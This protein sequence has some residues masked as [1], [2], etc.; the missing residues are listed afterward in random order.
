M[1]AQYDW[2]AQ[3]AHQWDTT[4]RAEGSPPSSASRICNT[5]LYAMF[6]M[7]LLVLMAATAASIFGEAIPSATLSTDVVTVRPIDPHV[8]SRSENERI[9]R[10]VALFTNYLGGV[11]KITVITNHY[12]E[13]GTG[14]C[15]QEADGTWK[16][17]KA[18]FVVTPDGGAEARRGL[19]KVRLKP[20]IYTIGAVQLTLPNGHSMSSAPRGLYLHDPSADKR[21]L[22]SSITNSIGT[23][24]APNTVVYSNCFDGFQAD[25]VLKVTPAGF[26]QD[27]VLR[28]SLSWVPLQELGL[29]PASTVLEVWT[30]FF[31]TPVP[32]KQ[33]T[34]ITARPTPE[35]TA[36]ALSDETLKF[37][38]MKMPRGRAFSQGLSNAIERQSAQDS[39]PVGK[40]WR[41]MEDGRRFLIEAARWREILPHFRSLDQGLSGQT[42]AALLPKLR[43]TILSSTSS[44]PALL[45][46]SSVQHAAIQ[47]AENTLTQPPA[48]ILDY[49]IV[50]GALPSYV[51]APAETYFISG[52]VTIAGETVLGPGAVLKFADWSTSA[53]L[54]FGGTVRC[55]SRAG[56]SCILTAKDDNSVGEVIAGS[57]GLPIEFYGSPALGFNDDA[58]PA[59]LKYVRI[60]YAE[61]AIDF[62]N[63][64]PNRVRHCQI[65][66]AGW[67]F[68]LHG[69][70]LTLHNVLSDNSGS[71]FWGYSFSVY[72][73]HVTAHGG[74]MM[75]LW[76]NDP[77]TA[78]FINSL[79]VG[80]P[81]C[82][83]GMTCSAPIPSVWLTSEPQPPV[84]ETSLYGA[85]YLPADSDY[86]GQGTA[87]IDAQL[88]EELKHK[89][90]R[91]P[92]VTL[93]G[94][95][96]A[97]LT[98]VPTVARNVGPN[99]DLGYSY[100]AVD[101]LV[102][103]LWLRGSATLLATNGVVVGLNASAGSGIRLDGA[104]K[105][106]SEGTPLNL[107]RF[108]E[109]RSVQERSGPSVPYF[110][111]F[112]REYSAPD[113]IEL[114]L[115]FTDLPGRAGLNWHLDTDGGAGIVS[116]SDCQVIGGGIRSAFTEG[117]N[118]SFALTNNLL[119]T[120]KIDILGSSA[121]QLEFRN[122]TFIRG[123]VSLSGGGSAW[124]VYDNIFDQVSL[125][126]SPSVG[127]SHNAY[128]L[129][130]PLPSLGPNYVLQ[131]PV[132][133]QQG[134][135]GRFYLPAGSSPLLSGGSRGPAQAALFHHTTRVTQ[136]KEGSK[137]P[138][139]AVDLG[140]HYVALQNGSPWDTDKDGVADIYEDRNN[141][142]AWD[143]ELT[144]WQDS[145][146]DQDGFADGGG[147]LLKWFLPV[148]F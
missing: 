96:S 144:D 19:H 116:W 67:A 81:V 129:T 45:G 44:P 22:V 35:G 140:F 5:S 93:S 128:Y 36:R 107:N 7:L 3:D 51:F 139:T 42:N 123:P 33:I 125:S 55:E 131:S 121:T 148:T 73:E 92:P 124:G 134:P 49:S 15:Y 1:E 59:E 82:P 79:L 88:Q 40:T 86:R 83:S 101:Y 141:N 77:C 27:V 85:H 98:L 23:I 30:E 102:Q 16:D 71:L 118:H 65:V 112:Y 63:T 66:N 100:D 47:L 126:A 69:N 110:T 115:R 94:V 38:S 54:M 24:T 105:L 106:I 31:E 10:R 12:T 41:E 39:V 58:P 75:D 11:P 56:A 14:L 103:G 70:S 18:E 108:V 138:D 8:I 120:T 137:E 25:L 21:V 60:S 32:E 29:D 57:T 80:I 113:A 72:A 26:E 95:S 2:H 132:N 64:G 78:T 109:M 104:S 13:L 87:S 17:A 61:R 74:S 43:S 119:R 133:Y 53:G 46:G 142:G 91:P 89:T 37:G 136:E 114:R 76:Y 4:G 117:I 6:K 130:T 135:L 28:E 34:T 48:F 62:D 143:G 97:N 146:T 9:W 84:F 68:V 52:P 99:F 111:T 20:D 90:T 122:N 127:N 147:L 145:D 50:N